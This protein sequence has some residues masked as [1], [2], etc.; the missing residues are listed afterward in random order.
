MGSANSAQQINAETSLGWNNFNT[1]DFE[2][3]TALKYGNK[4]IKQIFQE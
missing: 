4:E 1:S 3:E 2:S